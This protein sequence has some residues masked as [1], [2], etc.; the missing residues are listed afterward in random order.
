M[1]SMRDI[2]RRIK[3]I[4]STQQITKAMKM[5]AAAKLRRAQE[6]V[7]S[8]RPYSEKVQDVLGRL[9]TS[10]KDYSHPLMEKREV[11]KVGL[12]MLTGDRG[13]CGGYNANIIRMTEHMI[14]GTD[15]PVGLVAVGRRGRD[16]FRRRGIEITEEY[17]N[18]GDNPTYIQG[19]ELAKRL[20]ALYSEGVFDEIYILYTKFKSA[21]SMK[22]MTLKVLPV[23]PDE[24]EE[25]KE[26]E[27]IYEPSQAGVM[28]VLLP[29]YVETTVYQAL[30][31][32]K[33]SEHGARMTA[34]SSATD[35][36]VEIIAKLNLHLNRA[37]QAAIT[38]EISEIVSGAAAL[39]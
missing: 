9:A 24:G 34:M 37:R 16:Y 38:T 36:A 18:I 19:K 7:I 25:V 14:A 27:Y 35:N 5:V 11:K 15:K 32:S 6:S 4:K 8:S 31:E 33:A 2:R 17:I 20:M 22:P 29:S 12:V 10:T 28:D 39:Q 13:L 26:V 30:L 1:A 3:S 23:Q 21:M